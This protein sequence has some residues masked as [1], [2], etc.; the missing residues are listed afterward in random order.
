MKSNRIKVRRGGRGGRGAQ[1]KLK[2][3]YRIFYHYSRILRYGLNGT[4]KNYFTGLKKSKYICLIFS[5]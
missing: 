5:L 1:E 3:K 2:S 4:R